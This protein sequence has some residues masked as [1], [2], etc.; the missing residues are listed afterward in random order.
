M[1]NKTSAELLRVNLT[2]LEPFTDYTFSVDCVPLVDG[3]VLGFWSDA[4]SEQ[5]ATKEDGSSHYNFSLIYDLSRASWPASF[6]RI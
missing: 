5:F 1:L 3:K 4:V 6:C 2:D